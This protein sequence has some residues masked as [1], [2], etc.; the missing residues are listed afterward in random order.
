LKKKSSEQ[1]WEFLER[2][3]VLCE[4]KR[5][6]S[7]INTLF[8]RA[9]IQIQHN[10]NKKLEERESERARAREW[11]KKCAQNSARKIHAGDVGRILSVWAFLYIRG[12]RW[13]FGTAVIIRV[14]TKSR[15]L[16]L[17][18]LSHTMKK[19]VYIVNTKVRCFTIPLSA[20]NRIVA[21]I[22]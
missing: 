17:R 20:R 1:K 8:C 13:A 10:I 18:T 22:D 15:P 9:R 12:P 2:R 11:N 4:F 16:P 21:T 7:Q 5:R 3:K 19:M 14:K 6:T